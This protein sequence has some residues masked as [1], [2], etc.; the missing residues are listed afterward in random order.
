MERTTI[1]QAKLLFGSNF[2][3]SDE[4]KPL[5]ERMGFLFSSIQMPEIQYSL[6]DLKKYSKDYILILGISE[7]E[8]T[9]LSIANFRECFGM[10]S[11]ISEP[12]FYNQ[13]WYMNEE[14]IH[15]SLQLRWYL[16][17]KNVIE[18]SRAVQ[19]TELLKEHINFPTAILCVYTFFAYYYAKKEILWHHDFIWCN[20]TDHN[21]DRIY[22]GKYHDVDGV[23]K[24]GFSI[25]RHLALRKCYAAIKQI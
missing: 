3:G 1:E 8:G 6:D 20:D 13:D 17:R 21:G 2:I 23:N 22:V 19:P 16:L 15:D 9:K 24:N 11:A 5:F 18:S 10:N 7:L 14:F 12:C 25:H 4:L